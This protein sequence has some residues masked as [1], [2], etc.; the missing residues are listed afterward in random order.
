[1]P[2][3]YLVKRSKFL[4]RL[5]FGPKRHWQ[6]MAS[7]SE[8]GEVLTVALGGSDAQAA[9]VAVRI[10]DKLAERGDMTYRQLVTQ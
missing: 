3:K 1:L 7:M 2:L 10:V 5:L 4:E 9:Q 6:Y 8:V